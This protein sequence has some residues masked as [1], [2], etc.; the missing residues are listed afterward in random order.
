[1]LPYSS[2]HV[3]QRCVFMPVCWLI[4]F[5]LF[6]IDEPYSESVNKSKFL[7][8]KPDGA[9]KGFGRDNEVDFVTAWPS[10][11]PNWIYC[12]K[13]WDKDWSTKMNSKQH[14]HNQGKSCYTRFNYL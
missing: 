11:A 7:L 2:G 9:Q 6:I 10:L 5:K 14:K 12:H 4:W 13:T 1:M 8:R 3:R